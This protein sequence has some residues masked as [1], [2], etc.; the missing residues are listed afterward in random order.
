MVLPYHQGT[1]EELRMYKINAFYKTTN[2][3]RNTLIRIKDTILF[4]SVQNS[5][6][7]LGCVDSDKF[8][9]GKSSGEISTRA[10]EHLIHIKRPHNN[11]VELENLQVDSACYFQ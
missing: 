2:T 10:K 7:R 8:Y 11:P 1:T 5:V 3:L 4:N 9:I 6:Y